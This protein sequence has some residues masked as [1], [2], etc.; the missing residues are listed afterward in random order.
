MTIEEV[1]SEIDRV[2]E[3]SLF[4]VQRRFSKN[5]GHDLANACDMLVRKTHKIITDIKSAFEPCLLPVTFGEYDRDEIARVFTTDTTIEY[6][7]CEFNTDS[8]PSTADHWS[9]CILQTTNT[10]DAEE[11]SNRNLFIEYFE[12]YLYTAATFA[13]SIGSAAV[14]PYM[15][16]LSLSYET[17][18]FGSRIPLSAEE[19]LRLVNIEKAASKLLWLDVM[20]ARLPKFKESKPRRPKTAA[21]KAVRKGR[22][23]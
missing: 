2:N 12:N 18:S 9:D 23:A 6:D 4:D 22:K 11:A 21:R 13:K 7:F 3:E 17:A 14:R 5:T 8:D 10:T 1:Q 15:M 19:A 20:I 16:A